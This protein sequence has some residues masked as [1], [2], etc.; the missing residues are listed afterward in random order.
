MGML[1][2]MLRS[3][4]L[5]SPFLFR[6]HHEYLRRWIKDC[7]PVPT[8]LLQYSLDDIAFAFVELDLWKLTR[9]QTESSA[10]LLRLVFAN[11]VLVWPLP[12]RTG[13]QKP[14]LIPPFLIGQKKPGVS[15]MTI[16]DPL[17]RVEM[18]P[19]L[20]FSYE[21]RVSHQELDLTLASKPPSVQEPITRVP[22]ELR[23]IVNGLPGRTVQSFMTLRHQDPL[24]T[25]L[26]I[27][28][29]DLAANIGLEIDHRTDKVHA[30]IALLP[31]LLPASKA[32]ASVHLLIDAS[33]NELSIGII[34]AK[35]Q[36]LRVSTT[37]DGDFLPV[38]GILQILERISEALAVDLRYPD[39]GEELDLVSLLEAE[40]IAKSGVVE[41]GAGTVTLTG[42]D[43]T[44][45]REHLARAP[46]TTVVSEHAESS[47][48]VAGHVIQLGRVKREFVNARLCFQDDPTDVDHVLFECDVA[49][50][51]YLV[52]KAR[53]DARRVEPMGTI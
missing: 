38:R 25:H 41:N 5:L 20:H 52:W 7:A 12:E 3:A 6:Q 36:S 21:S 23:A 9:P 49:R 26:R 32:L 28:G 33:G 48:A 8:R 15:M 43:G 19:E 45:F 50:D 37:I 17:Q 46:G 1:Q 22:V 29:G 18:K 13:E 40:Q 44:Q 27:Q 16:K 39:R 31:T 2:A 24:R 4:W 14:C 11:I 53:A 47:L 10:L 34:G 30:E 42:E 51:T 35:E